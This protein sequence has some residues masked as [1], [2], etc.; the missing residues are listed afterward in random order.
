MR[1]NRGMIRELET[2]A[3][4]LKF[5][6]EQRG[7][8]QPQLA[9]AA[10][11][12]QPDISKIEN[13]GIVKTTGIARLAAA[14]EVSPLWLEMNEGPSP[15]WA[16]VQHANE[17][18]PTW[19][20]AHNLSHPQQTI[21]PIHLEWETLVTDKLPARF[22]LT[23][24]DESMSSNDAAGLSVGDR[25]IFETTREPRPGRNVLVRDRTGSLY[26]R[27]YRVRRPGHWQAVARHPAYQ[28][29]DSIEDDLVIVAVQTGHLY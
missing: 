19:Q 28:A 10:G 24:V 21:D 15:T 27:E 17:G 8:T 11:M 22:M 23:V 20:V 4:R 29:L 9:A 6:R 18:H 13:G 26:I 14:L 5:A 12:K 2:L 16:N 3:R 7:L 25:A 1:L